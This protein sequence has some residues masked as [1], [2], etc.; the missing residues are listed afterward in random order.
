MKIL[1]VSDTH[2]KKFKVPDDAFDS[3]YMIVAGD[4]CFGMGYIPEVKEAL[5][6]LAEQ[7]SELRIKRMIVTPGNHDGAFEW[8]LARKE[9]DIHLEKIKN[10]LGVDVIICIDE[11]LDLDDGIKAFIS[12]YHRMIGSGDLFAFSYKADMVKELFENKIPKDIDL[13]VTHGPPF[14]ILDSIKSETIHDSN[15]REYLGCKDFLKFL[16]GPDCKIKDVIFGH[17]HQSAGKLRRD[18]INYYNVATKAQVIH[19]P[20]KRV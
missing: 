17:I 6:M 12:P 2:S 9:I 5:T 20:N 18:N 19:L 13:L 11:I 3:D 7:A 10:D 1:A 14:G 16:Q 8:P 15:A 4:I